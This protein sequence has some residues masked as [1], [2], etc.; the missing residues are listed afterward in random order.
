MTPSALALEIRSARVS[1]VDAIARLNNFFA[2]QH[3]M[4][5]KSLRQGWVIE[6]AAPVHPMCQAQL[7]RLSAQGLRIGSVYVVSADHIQLPSAGASCQ[8]SEYGMQA[9]ARNNIADKQQA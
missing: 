5:A 3:I 1:E 6:S 4:L 8:R 2:D 7:C 9:L